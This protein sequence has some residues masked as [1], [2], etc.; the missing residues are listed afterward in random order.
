[1]KNPRPIPAAFLAP[2]KFSVSHIESEGTAT[3]I[4]AGGLTFRGSRGWWGWLWG[5]LEPALIT[6]H[7]YRITWILEVNY[8]K[9]WNHYT[10]PNFCSCN[11]LSTLPEYTVHNKAANDH[12]KYGLHRLVARGEF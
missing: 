6:R 5:L 8:N 11:L 7:N 1:L 10:L 12:V 3:Q 9:L 2:G 4:R